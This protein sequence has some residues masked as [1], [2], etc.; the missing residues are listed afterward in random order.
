[1]A[2]TPRPPRPNKRSGG[3]PIRP[4]R[5][6]RDD[7]KSRSAAS[8]A[9]RP[10]KPKSAG[11]R[12]PK[13]S[14]QKPAKSIQPRASEGTTRSLKP[15]SEESAAKSI[16]PRLGEGA[17]RSS[18]PRLGEG[19][20]KPIRPRSDDSAE[21]PAKPRLG[22]GA[23]KYTKP[24]PDEGAAKYTKPRL[25]ESAAKYTKPG[26]GEGTANY[27]KPRFGE[28][29]ARGNGKLSLIKR[30]DPTGETPE[31][32]QRDGSHEEDGPELL[33]GKQAALAA[34]QSGRALNR[35]WLSERLRYDPRFLRLIDDAKS[36]GA[37]ID[38]VDLKRLDQITDG[39]NHQGI[40]AQVAAYPY[41]ELEDLIE[42]VQSVPNPVLLAC[43]GIE[44]PQNL[45]ALIRSA[46][47][48]GIQ[49]LLIPHRRAAGIT[50]TVA[51]VAAGALEHLPISRVVNLN[52]ALERL[53]EAGFWIVGTQEKAGQA[54][55]DLE[56]TGPL[57]VVVGSEG[58]GISLL[59]QR[60]CDHM[61]SI[62]LA[63]K[64]PSLNAAVAGGIVLYELVRQRRKLSL[65]LG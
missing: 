17:Q 34:L 3:K 38:I 43:D 58:K 51:K 50:A 15:R 46:E 62:P 56:L 36:Q 40:A 44:D 32:S 11:Q 22:E 1:M 29:V 42:R 55:Y 57:I 13:P 54:I 59:T 53:K 48:F 35:V 14:A 47:A 7:K 52:Q 30:L 61:A 6:G 27:T 31:P 24:R 18:K 39:G 64:T 9:A 65:N 33:Y 26:L 63:G 8:G 12:K 49:G 37:V 4:E 41:V 21:K 5:P 16:K 20:V 2:P 60:H 45:G 10:G 28:G 23:A 19:A 25:G